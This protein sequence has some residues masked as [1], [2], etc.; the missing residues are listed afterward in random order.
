M[1]EGSWSRSEVAETVTGSTEGP[2]ESGERGWEVSSVCGV[3][4]PASV[5]SPHVRGVES[6]TRILL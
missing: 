2:A 3:L 6:W 1:V 4:I 5:S